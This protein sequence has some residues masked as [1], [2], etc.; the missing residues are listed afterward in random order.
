MERR[1]DRMAHGE[2]LSMKQIFAAAFLEQMATRIDDPSADLPF[3]KKLGR[4][5]LAW[6]R[7]QL[8]KTS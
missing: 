8:E 3:D 5:V 6:L 1:E 7:G 2:N 4:L